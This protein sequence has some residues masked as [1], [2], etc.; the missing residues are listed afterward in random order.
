MRKLLW[1][2]MLDAD[3]NARYWD[4][5]IRRHVAFEQ[6][7]RVLLAVLTSGTAASL[8]FSLGADWVW[9][10]MST[11]SAVTSIYLTTVGASKPVERMASIK[12][13]WSQCL[14]QYEHQWIQLEAGG[15]QVA[16]QHVFEKTRASQV[17]GTGEESHFRKLDEVLVSCQQAVRRSRGL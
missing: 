3:M 5:M 1:E 2:S 12:N 11:A 15:D 8:V 13:C 9:K 14:I 7:L 10:A 17:A 6:R 16:L 4:D